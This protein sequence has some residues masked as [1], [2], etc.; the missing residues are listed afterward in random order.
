MFSL[1]A[2][3]CEPDMPDGVFDTSVVFISYVH[4]GENSPKGE[5]K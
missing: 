1:K 4:M 3:F 2:A 5:I